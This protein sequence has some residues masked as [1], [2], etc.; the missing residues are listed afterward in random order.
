MGARLVRVPCDDL[1]VLLTNDDD[2]KPPEIFK[3]RHDTQEQLSLLETGSLVLVYEEEAENGNDAPLRI[4]LVGWKGKTSVRAYVPKNE[5]IHYLRLCGADISKF[6]HNKFKER[7][8]QGDGLK[9]E[10]SKDETEGNVSE[11]VQE[12]TGGLD[13]DAQ[14]SGS[15]FCLPGEEPMCTQDVDGQDGE[16]E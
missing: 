1:V 10:T 15:Q 9:D 11:D 14:S 16:V 12:D 3:L 7:E 5:R 6:E 8:K 2:H 13:G 4:E